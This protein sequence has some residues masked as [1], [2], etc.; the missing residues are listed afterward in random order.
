MHICGKI[1]VLQLIWYAQREYTN[2]IFSQ[3]WLSHKLQLLNVQR[4]FC[5]VMCYHNL[6][7]DFIDFRKIIYDYIITVI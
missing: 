5:S 7:I 3:I 2:L 1:L 4:N 6:N